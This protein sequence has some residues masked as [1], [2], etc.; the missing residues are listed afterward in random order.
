MNTIVLYS[1]LEF[2]KY[3]FIPSTSTNDPTIKI[4]EELNLKRLL[5]QKNNFYL[6]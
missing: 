5:E 2:W 4:Y 1:I 3:F 6:P